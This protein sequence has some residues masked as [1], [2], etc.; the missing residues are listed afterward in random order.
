LLHDGGMDIGSHTMSHARLTTL[1][2]EQALEE[3]EQSK[4]IIEKHLGEP[5]DLLAYPAGDY[6]QDVEDLAVEAG[7]EG[8]FTTVAGPVRPGDDAF[9]LRRI[10]VWCGGY[11]GGFGKHFS[12]TVF[13]LQISRL[14]RRT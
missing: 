12:P 11:R 2:V 9:A 7:Y 6:N 1:P 8:A 14:A 10:G 4:K 5:I 13:G 3:L